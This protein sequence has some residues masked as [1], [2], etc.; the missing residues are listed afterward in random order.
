MSSVE[1]KEVGAGQ[2]REFVMLPFRLYKGDAYWVAPLIKDQVKLLGGGSHFMRATEHSFLMAYRDGAACGR[3]LVGKYE[4]MRKDA[5]GKAYFSLPEADSP[6]VLEQLIK[7]AEG[8][9]RKMGLSGMIGPWSPTDTDDD[10][11]LL[12]EGFEGPPSLMGPYN[13][14]WYKDVFEANGYSKLVDFISYRLVKYPTGDERV[15]RL[16]EIAFKRTRTVIS[17]FNRKDL[18][19]DIKDL[20][21]VMLAAVGDNPDLPSPTWEQFLPEAERL[22]KM[23]DDNLILIARK[24]SDNSPVAFVAAMPNWSEVLKKIRGRVFPFGWVHA[25][26]A[27]KRIKGV[28]VFMQFCIPEYR[29]SG[30][31]PVLYA[32][33]RDKVVEG[34]YEYWEAG[35][36]RDDNMPSRKPVEDVG[37]KLFRTYRWYQK[38]LD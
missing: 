9:A 6:E 32:K 23:A 10:K 3:I 35:T 22:A 16:L 26:G 7:A 18:M 15:Q 4:G 37:G 21:T 36:I 30:I 24:Q 33:L 28:R 19:K 38:E 14:Q 17:T 8:W 12:I 29:G 31:L 2:L 20:H 1:I 11:G 34:G 27:K 5:A 13:K 25:I